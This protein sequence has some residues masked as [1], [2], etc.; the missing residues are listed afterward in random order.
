LVP[1]EEGAKE[2]LDYLLIRFDAGRRHVQTVEIHEP[3]GD[4]TRIRFS[5]TLLNQPLDPALF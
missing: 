2:F 4:F 1:R 3:G 5:E